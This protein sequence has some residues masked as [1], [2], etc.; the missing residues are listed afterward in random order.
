M[1]STGLLHVC[2]VGCVA[3]L[4][5]CGGSSSKTA[6]TVGSSS[7]PSSSSPA[8]SPSLA[9]L[10]QLQKIVL[11]PADLPAGWKGTPY[12]PSESS[13]ADQAAF[14]KCV[15]VRNTDADTVA[16][17]D[18]ADY[19]LGDASISS[20]ATS[21]RSQSD[22]DADTAAL[23]SPKAS[24]C[25]EKVLKQSLATTGATV[26]SV[27]VKITP[28]SAGGPANVVATLVAAIKI[29]RAGRQAVLYSTAAFITGPLIEAEVDTFNFGTPV[30]ASLTNPLVATVANRAA[31]PLSGPSSSKPSSSPT[32]KLVAYRG[33]K[34]TVSM[35]GKPRTST[36]RQST[37]VGKLTLHLLVVDGSSASYLVGYVDYPRGTQTSI[38]GAVQGAANNIGGRAVDVKR[39]TY[40]HAEARDFRIIGNPQGT[41]FMRV[42]IV[43][44]RLYELA[45]TVPETDAKSPPAEF[46]LMLE[47]LRF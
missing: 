30:P 22:V 26:K 23:L 40:R 20:S 41:V 29:S 21:Y 37:A 28:G 2:A 35:P 43:G 15:G 27:S 42:V 16:E 24:P 25:F 14:V 45:V 39:I 12:Q 44:L 13:A 18:S 7:A 4:A 47:S 38:E 10:P 19:S 32:S 33:D 34:F 9:S 31:H 5:A 3:V 46:A 17:A 1:K 8:A 6:S 36:Q 11:Q